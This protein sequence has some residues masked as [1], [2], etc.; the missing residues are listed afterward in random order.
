MVPLKAGVLVLSLAWHSAADT[1]LWFF[2]SP[3]AELV[4]QTMHFLNPLNFPKS[5]QGSST[6]CTLSTAARTCWYNFIFAAQ[7]VLPLDSDTEHAFYMANQH[8]CD[9]SSDLSLLTC[10][11]LQTTTLSSPM[12]WTTS[13]LATWIGTLF[14]PC[15][16]IWLPKYSI[17]ILLISN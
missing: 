3:L 10:W 16:L 11:S 17:T 12:R 4:L 5:S 9:E 15:L 8:Y 13:F 14:P 7:K 2:F 6:A 1:T